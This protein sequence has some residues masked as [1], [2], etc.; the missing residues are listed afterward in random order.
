MPLVD[1]NLSGETPTT[2][3]ARGRN[4]IAPCLSRYGTLADLTKNVGTKNG[5]DG[6]GPG[7]GNMNHAHSCLRP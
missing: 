2:D 6:S 7:C 3:M 5:N 4:Y 1:V